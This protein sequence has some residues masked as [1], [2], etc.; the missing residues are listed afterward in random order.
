MKNVSPEYYKYDL[1][2]AVIHCGTLNNGHYWTWFKS[3]NNWVKADDE[4]IKVYNTVKG[5]QFEGF[6]GDH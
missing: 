2:G 1:C 6:G 5:V 3:N 4:K